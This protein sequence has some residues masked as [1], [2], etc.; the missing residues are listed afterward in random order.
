[1]DFG[2][3]SPGLFSREL[4]QDL[5]RDH[6]IFGVFANTLSSP[7]LPLTATDELYRV[8]TKSVPRSGERIR[9]LLPELSGTRIPLE[10]PLEQGAVYFI[11]LRETLVLPQEISAT[12]SSPLQFPGTISLLC[13]GH[14]FFNTAPHGYT[15]ELWVCIEPDAGPSFVTPEAALGSLGFFLRSATISLGE[16]LSYHHKNPLFFNPEGQSIFPLTFQ[17][18]IFFTTASSIGGKYVETVEHLRLPH[19]IAARLSFGNRSF[20]LL[21]G[22]GTASPGGQHLSLPS[23]LFAGMLLRSGQPLLSIEMLRV[24]PAPPHPK[25]LYTPPPPESEKS[26]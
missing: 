13:D 9:Q 4:V 7:F 17:E 23:F 3:I 8:S 19:D 6:H 5:V 26:G 15:G 14:P 10:S 2:A 25:T 1:M 18:K 16:V 21:P 11:R 20:F 22:F 24:S 12:F